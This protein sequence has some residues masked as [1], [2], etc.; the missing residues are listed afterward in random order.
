MTNIITENINGILF[1]E[2]RDYMQSMIYESMKALGT[3]QTEE[4][5][6]YEDCTMEEYFHEWQ[7]IWDEDTKVG[8]GIDTIAHRFVLND[9][10]RADFEIAFKHARDDAFEGY[11]KELAEETED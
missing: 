3:N 11:M 10:T 6:W 5:L 1:N 8:E 2:L 9:D 7:E 4:L